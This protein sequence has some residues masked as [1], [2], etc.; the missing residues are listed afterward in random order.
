MEVIKYMMLEGKR[1]DYLKYS[2]SSGDTQTKGVLVEVEY[3][4]RNK[5]G[6]ITRETTKKIFE[7]EKY[8]DNILHIKQI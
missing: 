8:I 4:K 3:Y 1:F 6:L 5:S 2:F 7:V